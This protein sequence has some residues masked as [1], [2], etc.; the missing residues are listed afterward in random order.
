MALQ[1]L[2]L[3]PSKAGYTVTESAEA[4][5]RAKVGAGLPRQRLD[6]ASAPQQVAVTFSLDQGQYRYWRAFWRNGI[7]YGTLPF[8]IDLT[9]ED[10]ELAE[11]EAMFVPGSVSLAD[12]SGLRYQISGVLDVKPNVADMEYDDALI[13]LYGLYGDDAK[14]MLNLLATL[15][16]E[17]LPSAIAG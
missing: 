8:L 15:V 1:K 6:F 2:N 7:A 4:V 14:N 16:N 17:D 10:Y 9:I 3:L 5:L 13:M 11:Y 12:V